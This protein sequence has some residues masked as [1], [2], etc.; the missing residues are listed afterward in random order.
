M[1]LLKCTS[2]QDGYCDSVL[3]YSLNDDYSNLDETLE[4]ILSDF[5][6]VSQRS[7]FGEFETYDEEFDIVETDTNKKICH[8]IVESQLKSSFKPK[9]YFNQFSLNG[10][11][12]IKF[13][14]SK[15]FK[16]L[17]DDKRIDFELSND[18]DY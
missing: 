3:N 4:D 18:I 7:V 13:I 8:V 16:T 11:G 12:S 2:D 17:V 10:T 6:Y 1:I 14:I 15:D 5:A 9:D